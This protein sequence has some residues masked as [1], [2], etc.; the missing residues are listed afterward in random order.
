MQFEFERVHPRVVCILGSGVH[1]ELDTWAVQFEG[2]RIGTITRR[3]QI[4]GQVAGSRCS[5]TARFH[6]LLGNV[7]QSGD[8]PE[9]YRSRRQ[10][11][12]ALLDAA[13]APP[14]S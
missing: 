9:V 11:A 4:G 7:I 5:W 10:A 1:A 2:Q 14:C 3:T 12:E 13:T 8:C 6:R